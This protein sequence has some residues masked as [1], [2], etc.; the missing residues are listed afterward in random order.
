MAE[1]DLEVQ[2]DFERLRSC[3]PAHRQE[4]AKETGL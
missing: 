2:E 4:K 1:E 3:L